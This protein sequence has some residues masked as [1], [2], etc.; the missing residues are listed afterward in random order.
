MKTINV[1]LDLYEWLSILAWYASSDF[2]VMSEEDDLY[3]KL[4][5]KIF[6]EAHD[7]VISD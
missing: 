2:P 4:K 6:L 1:E 5:D 3:E 7:D